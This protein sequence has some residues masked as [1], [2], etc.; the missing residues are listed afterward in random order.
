MYV[1]IKRPNTQGNLKLKKKKK[2]TEGIVLPDLKS[3][4]TRV[5]VI[6][7]TWHKNRNT[8]Q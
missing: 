3:K 6:K 8:D 2:K 1:F 4:T 7:A 5:M